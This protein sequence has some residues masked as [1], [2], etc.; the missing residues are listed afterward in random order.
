MPRRSAPLRIATATAITVLRTTT[1][2]S[3][4][5]PL[6]VVVVGLG[7]GGSGENDGQVAVGIWGVGRQ[8]DRERPSVYQSLKK[9]SATST[10]QSCHISQVTVQL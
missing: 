1:P 10:S 7:L 2:C 4:V 3:A 8:E 6:A 9:H 5:P